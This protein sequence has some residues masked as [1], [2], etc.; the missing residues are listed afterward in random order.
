MKFK[1]VIISILIMVVLVNTNSNCY[2]KYVFEYIETA[3]KIVI[4]N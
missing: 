1:K 2:A 4:N 3:A